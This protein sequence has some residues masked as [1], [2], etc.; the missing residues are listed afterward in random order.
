MAGATSDYNMIDYLARKW[1][2]VCNRI[3]LPRFLHLSRRE[4]HVGNWQLRSSGSGT[5][6]SLPL[7]HRRRTN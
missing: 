6:P 7:E 5:G 2:E 1:I 3:R 4:I